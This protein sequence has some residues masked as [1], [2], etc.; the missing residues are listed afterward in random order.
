MCAA[1]GTAFS[2]GNATISRVGDLQLGG[3]YSSAS[4]DYL[5]NR[6][7]GYTFY[8]DFDFFHNLGVEV[9]FHNVSDSPTKVYERT[10]EV[11]VRYVRHYGRL[12]PYAKLL[13]GRGQFNYP[14]PSDEMLAYNMY[15]VGGGLDYAVLPRVNVRADYEYQ[16]WHSFTPNGLTPQVITIG[17][18]YHFPS[19]N[20]SAR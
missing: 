17:V 1:T 5:S 4:S 12:G 13:V 14:V 3:G 20:L 10:Y 19:G 7:S 8:G 2:Q 11:G 6:I 15:S 18:A 9:D 16:S